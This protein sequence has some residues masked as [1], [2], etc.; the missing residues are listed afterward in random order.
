M[1]LV[2]RDGQDTLFTDV[3]FP[4]EAAAVRKAGG[5]VVRVVRDGKIHRA[6]HSSEKIKFPIDAAFTI[7]S[8][9][10]NRVRDVALGVLAMINAPR[11][12][13]VRLS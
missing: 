4:N 13:A 7:A 9:D 1:E 3:R 5:L 10:L 6:A 11:E 8:G 2:R 12:F